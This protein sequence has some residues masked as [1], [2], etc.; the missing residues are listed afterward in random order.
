MLQRRFTTGQPHA[1]FPQ[2]FQLRHL[3]KQ[4]RYELPPAGEP[5]GVALRLVLLH[6]PCEFPVWKQLQ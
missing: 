6:C 4:H 3:A 5:L 2:R 1:N